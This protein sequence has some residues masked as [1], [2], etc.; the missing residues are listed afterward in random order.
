MVD[1]WRA[2]SDGETSHKPRRAIEVNKAAACAA[3]FGKGHVA[4][5]KRL[6]VPSMAFE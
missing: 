6:K 1:K 3:Q 4:L 2:S 5:E